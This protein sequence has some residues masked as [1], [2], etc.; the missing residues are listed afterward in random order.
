MD[1]NVMPWV[2]DCMADFI[3]DEDDQELNLEDVIRDAF[4]LTKIKHRESIEKKYQ[5]RRDA[6]AEKE[7]IL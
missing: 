6:I 5:R 1:E 4:E 7:L 2:L 3:D